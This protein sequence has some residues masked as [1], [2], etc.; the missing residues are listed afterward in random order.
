MALRAAGPGRLCFASGVS[1]MYSLQQKKI[2]SWPFGQPARGRLCF[3][4]GVS[5]MY[6]LQQKKI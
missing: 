5:E 2:K 6:S 4:S 1:E 3:A